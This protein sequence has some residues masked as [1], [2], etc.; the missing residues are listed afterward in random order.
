ACDRHTQRQS[1]EVVA[2]VSRAGRR[3]PILVLVEESDFGD[4]Y[5]LMKMGVPYYYEFREGAKRIYGALSQPVSYAAAPLW[6]RGLA[7][8]REAQ[9]TD[10][11]AEAQLFRETVEKTNQWL[12]ELSDRLEWDE[13]RRV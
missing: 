9:K 7:M 6:K 8:T 4:Y 13:P 3:V 5:D 2:S 11:I 1:R 12:R 10:A